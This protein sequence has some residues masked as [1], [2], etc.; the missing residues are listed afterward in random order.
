MKHFKNCYYVTNIFFFLVFLCFYMFIIRQD[1]IQLNAHVCPCYIPFPDRI[2]HTF[3]NCFMLFLHT[4][5]LEI[6]PNKACSD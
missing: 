2:T 5:D 1:N 3:L 4:D 6:G